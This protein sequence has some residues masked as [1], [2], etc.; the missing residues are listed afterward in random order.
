MPL[1]DL[2]SELERDVDAA[3]D[4]WQ[5]GLVSEAIAA[6][7]ELARAH[8]EAPQVHGLLG[9]YL[10]DNDQAG[11]GLPFLRRAVALAPDFEMASIAL[12]HALYDIGA[13][14]EAVAELQRFLEVRDSAEHR[15]FLEAIRA[16]RSAV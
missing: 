15:K 4:A 2:T 1:P 8:P 13:E 7:S 11:L 5:S 10:W 14:E 9:M 16:G 12:F 3:I 6:L